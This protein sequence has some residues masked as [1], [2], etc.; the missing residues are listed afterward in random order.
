MHEVCTLGHVERA[1]RK[2]LNLTDSHEI[3]GRQR[4]ILVISSTPTLL[5][6][7]IK[8]ALGYHGRTDD[9]FTILPVFTRRWRGSR[10][11]VER[12]VAMIPYSRLD[13]NTYIHSRMHTYTCVPNAFLE[14]IYDHS[15]HTWSRLHTRGFCPHVD[16]KGNNREKKDAFAETVRL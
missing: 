12:P 6:R 9:V 11:L 16:R 2:P 7:P 3:I 5:R 14:R 8:R 15:E 1:C 4:Y 10:R 13:R